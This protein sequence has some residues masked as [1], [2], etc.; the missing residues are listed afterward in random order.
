MIELKCPNCSADIELD[1]SRE[2]GFC[3]YCGTRVLIE[4]NKSKVDGIAGID[5]LLLRAAEFY[6]EKNYIEA[7]EYYNRVL[8]IDINNSYAKQGLLD[9]Q[10]KNVTWH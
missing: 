6:K 10:Q 7:A 9:I 4:L 8:D 2:I 3:R 1:D 5:N